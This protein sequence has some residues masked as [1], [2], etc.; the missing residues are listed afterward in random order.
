MSTEDQQDGKI[1][2]IQLRQALE[3]NRAE[4]VK[5]LQETKLPSSN[6]VLVSVM[7]QLEESSSGLITK[8]EVL[9]AI[10][11]G[12][13]EANIVLT[14]EATEGFVATVFSKA[15][16]LNQGKITR[17]ALFEAL[18]EEDDEAMDLFGT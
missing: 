4:T 9:I 16:T 6:A 11:Q 15:D 3:S 10:A 1:T 13:Q 12:A 14:P 7:K 5:V 8:S 17:R 2:R 18:D